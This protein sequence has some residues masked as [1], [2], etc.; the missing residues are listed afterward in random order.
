MAFIYSP[1]DKFGYKDT[2]PEGHPEK[3]IKGSE[4]DDVFNNISADSQQSS[5]ALAQEIAARIAGDLHLQNQINDILLNGGGGDGGEPG[6]VRWVDVKEKPPQ[7]AILGSPQ[8]I[9]TGGSY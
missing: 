5:D 4:F 6:Y 3:V 7:I 2:L 8:N 1:K 9:I